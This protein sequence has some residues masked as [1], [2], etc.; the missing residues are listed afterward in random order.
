MLQATRRFGIIVG[1]LLTVAFLTGCAAH[2]TS[3]VTGVLYTDV[4]GPIT[5]T[6]SDTATLKSGSATVTSI[7]GLIAT[8]DASIESAARD[9]GITKIHHVDYTAKSVLGLYAEY[10]VIVFG[11]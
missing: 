6:A 7:L 5:A 9:G 2:V 11:E 4:K 8:G 3:P 1:L 10:T